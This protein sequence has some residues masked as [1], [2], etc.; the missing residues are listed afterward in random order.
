MS[1]LSRATCDIK[2]L[3]QW[4]VLR[5]S[6]RTATSPRSMTPKCQR[7]CR[8]GHR[9]R[10]PHTLLILKISPAALATSTVKQCCAKVC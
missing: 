8:Y 10:D 3:L 7:N 2:S 6:L 5:R 1:R 9:E 4:G